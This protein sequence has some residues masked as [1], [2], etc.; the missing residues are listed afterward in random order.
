MND[1][2]KIPRN[3]S[4]IRRLALSFAQQLTLPVFLCGCLAILWLSPFLWMIAASLRSDSGG[5]DIAS[6]VPQI[7]PSLKYFSDAFASANWKSLYLNTIIFTFGTLAVQLVTITMAGYAFAFGNFRGRDVLFQLFLIQLMLVPVVLM[8]PNMITL[9]SFH[10]LDTL[11]GLMAPYFASAFGVFLVRQAFKGVPR[12]M[13]EAALVEGAN[14]LQILIHI[15]IPAIWPVLLAF[16]IISVTYHWNEYLWPLM[17]L[18][19]PDKQVLTVGL[20]SF[21]MGAEAG[22]EWGL[23]AAGT[24]M[25]C[26]PLMIAFICFQKQFVSSFGFTEFK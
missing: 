24:L 11:T 25:V 5:A 7:P 4:E 2:H 18:N 20:V 13:E 8:V 21:A 10:L 9:K 14:F 15:L 17:V 22:A 26:L 23:I 3:C 1:K 6:V 12:E 19:D 16:S